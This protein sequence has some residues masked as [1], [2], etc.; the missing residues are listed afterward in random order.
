MQVA[1]FKSHQVLKTV[2]MTAVFFRNTHTDAQSHTNTPNTFKALICLTSYE[3]NVRV[4]CLSEVVD[5]CKCLLLLD[6]AQA[7]FTS[8]TVA[9]KDRALLPTM[10]K[11]G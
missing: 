2:T 7:G 6:R 5:L 4:F 10:S 3:G 8:T 1:S 11:T 9:S